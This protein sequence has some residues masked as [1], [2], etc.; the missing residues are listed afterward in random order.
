MI[1]FIADISAVFMEA[2]SGNA[3]ISVEFRNTATKTT[4]FLWSWIRQFILHKFPYFAEKNC[5]F[6]VSAFVCVPPHS[7]KLSLLL[8]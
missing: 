3:P 6:S 7:G 1:V 2:S 5:F 4:S 8:W